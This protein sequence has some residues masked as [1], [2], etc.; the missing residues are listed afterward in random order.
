M[1]TCVKERD[2]PT[3]TMCEDI[4]TLVCKAQCCVDKPLEG[5]GSLKVATTPVVA[6]REKIAM[7]IGSDIFATIRSMPSALPSA[8]ARCVHSLIQKK[9][10]IRRS[11]VWRGDVATFGLQTN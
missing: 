7:R 11:R 2:Q 3:D 5:F 8:S 10:C 9:R 6:E 4:E 1:L